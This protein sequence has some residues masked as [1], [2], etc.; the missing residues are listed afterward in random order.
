MK[1][2]IGAD[3]TVEASAYAA[4]EDGLTRQA[5]DRLLGW[6]DPDREEAGRKYEQIRAELI[7]IFESRRCMNPE[8]LADE[9]INRVAGKVE[10]IAS[11][12]SGQPGLYFYGVARIVH[13]EYTRRPAHPAPQYQRVAAEETEERH[14]CLDR[15]I[16]RLTPSNRELILL[17]YK[18][19]KQ[20][21]IDLRRELAERMGIGANAL[22]IRVF[23]IREA[24]AQCLN[25]CLRQE[26]GR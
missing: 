8:D 15:C 3:L 21:K 7:K 23:R 12:Y 24:L 1:A 25:D 10:Q 6:L 22:R 9:T 13:L 5:F 14:Q 20:S 18:E 4:R 19:D 11:A 16:E 2:S 17:Y 26:E